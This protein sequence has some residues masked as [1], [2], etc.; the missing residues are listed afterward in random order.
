[1]RIIQLAVITLFFCCLLC[2]VSWYDFDNY[3][4][5]ITLAVCKMQIIAG[6][7]SQVISEQ[8]IWGQWDFQ[9][10]STFTNWAGALGF[11]FWN[12]ISAKRTLNF[13]IFMSKIKKQTGSKKSLMLS[14]TILFQLNFSL[15]SINSLFSFTVTIILHI[16]MCSA[17]KQSS[18]QADNQLK[19][20][21]F[22]CISIVVK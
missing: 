9:M 5:L 14:V 4:I 20:N 19:E 12:L 22:I 17:G 7:K 11:K 6:S 8:N 3:Y 2:Y 13:L 15:T 1:M 21:T 18:R 16:K 10:L